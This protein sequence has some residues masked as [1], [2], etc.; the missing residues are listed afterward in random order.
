MNKRLPFTRKMFDL[1]I[2]CELERYPHI[3]S[4]PCHTTVG[5]MLLELDAAGWTLT[6][7]VRPHILKREPPII[8]DG[9]PPAK[10]EVFLCD[11]M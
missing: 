9:M 7:I 8:C 4:L 3:L 11:E 6:R 5:N 2:V 10:D 1:P